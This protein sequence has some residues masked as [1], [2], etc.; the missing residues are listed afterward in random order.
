M[1]NIFLMFIYLIGLLS[2]LAVAGFI[3]DWLELD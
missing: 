2:V 3:A 1:E